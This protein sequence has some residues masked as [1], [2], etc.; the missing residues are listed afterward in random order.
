MGRR[1]DIDWE[2]IQ[3]LYVAG[4]LTV[5][6]I[7]DECN[8]TPQS[9]T[10][11]VKTQGWQ[12]N[13][14]DAIRKRSREKIAQID[15]AHIIEESAKE[16]SNQSAQTIKSAIEAA[17]NVAAGVV[18]RHRKHYRE[19][20][21]RGDMLEAEFVRLMQSGACTDLN[22]LAKASSA[23]KTIVDA[24]AKLTELERKS[25]GLDALEPEDDRDVDAM[26]ASEAW[27]VVSEALK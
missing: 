25:F 17:S 26:P 10:K 21:E 9:I 19:Q 12:R 20:L 1:N 24:K 5:R 15:I 23:Y 27:K 11:K 16:S 3:S 2:K 7:A 8:V 22:E 14:A 4:Q 13:L 6:Q 18:L